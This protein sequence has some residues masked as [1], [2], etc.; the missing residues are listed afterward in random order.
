[1]VH[2][3]TM[4]VQT[5]QQVAAGCNGCAGQHAAYPAFIQLATRAGVPNHLQGLDSVMVYAQ[6]ACCG[7]A[8]ILVLAIWASGQT[9]ADLL[10]DPR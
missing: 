8:V 9:S 6:G 7:L 1:M 4:H 3:A 10:N 2:G 5:A